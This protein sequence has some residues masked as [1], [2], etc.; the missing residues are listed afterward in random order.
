M[1]EN[2]ENNEQ[3]ELSRGQ[4]VKLDNDEICRQGNGRQDNFRN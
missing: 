3:D 2:V 4:K 1:L